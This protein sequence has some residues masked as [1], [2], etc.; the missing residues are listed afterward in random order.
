M[1]LEALL[2]TDSAVS[3]VI[4]VVLMVAVTV[5]LASV[6]AAFVFGLGGTSESAPGTTF[7]F[8]YSQPTEKMVVF[9]DGGDSFDADHVTLSGANFGANETGQSWAA[10]ARSNPG[11]GSSTT[12]VSIGDTATLTQV[13]P[14]YLVEVVWTAPDGQSSSVIGSRTGPARR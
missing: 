5:I 6:I 9:V 14:D 8:E 2:K 13:Q 7:A 3:T 4:G 12:R 1:E 10:I 11:A